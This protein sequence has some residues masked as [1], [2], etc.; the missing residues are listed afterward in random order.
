[1]TLTKWWMLLLIPVFAFVLLSACDEDD[2][3]STDATD[4]D[5]EA[6]TPCQNHEDCDTDKELCSLG[7]CVALTVCTSIK[8]CLAGEVCVIKSGNVAG[9]CKPKS[10]V[11]GDDEAEPEKEI[12]KDCTPN[13]TRCDPF[14]QTTIQECKLYKERYDWRFQT[15]CSPGHCEGAKCVGMPDGDQEEQ[16][17]EIICETD[18]KQCYD[19]KVQQCSDDRTKW[20]TIDPCYTGTCIEELPN[21]WCGPKLICQPKQQVCDSLGRNAINT[22]ND[23]GTAWQLSWCTQLQSCVDGRCQNTGICTRGRYRCTGANLEQCNEGGTA[24]VKVKQC[25]EGTTC[26]CATQDCIMGD[27]ITNVICQAMIETRCEGN[28]VQRCASDGKA[29]SNW[30]NCEDSEQ[31]CQGGQCI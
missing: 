26:M 2:G 30:T 9:V 19:N 1:M 31:I 3:K 20:E 4:G 10:L 16:E 5:V 28:W 27:C 13:A 22:C 18:A 17:L 23:D 14:D 25:S 12:E 8:D 11:D 15:D 29:W 24:W 7:K 21:A 6:P